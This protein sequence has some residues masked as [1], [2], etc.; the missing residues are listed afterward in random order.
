PSQRRPS[1]VIFVGVLALL[2]L[3]VG[4]WWALWPDNE[5]DTTTI[6]ADG[7]PQSSGDDGTAEPSADT[8]LT[9]LVLDPAPAGYQPLILDESELGMAG[10]ADIWG[11]AG[12]E[13]PFVEGDLTVIRLPS[14][15]GSQALDGFG[16]EPTIEIAGRTVQPLDEEDGIQGVAWLD[17]D[18]ATAVIVVSFHFDRQV[19]IE[20]ASELLTTGRID[21]RGLD[22]LAEDAPWAPGPRLLPGGPGQAIY[23]HDS[24]FNDTPRPEDRTDVY[25]IATFDPSDGS[26]VVA[27]WFELITDEESVLESTT[28]P[29]TIGD[30]TG[31]LVTYTDGYDDSPR[32]ELRFQL[33]DG[34]RARISAERV[35]VEELAALAV[36]ARRA[37]PEEV[38]AMKDE[39]E[40]MV[41]EE[42][43]MS[44]S[45]STMTAPPLVQTT[46][47]SL[48]PGQTTFP[49]TTIT[50]P[51]TTLTTVL[52][53][54][55]ITGPT[56]EPP[57][58]IG[59]PST[60]A[61]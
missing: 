44:T 39:Y 52:P 27:A 3:A 11:R 34:T 46:D 47:L 33:L 55:S 28:E 2:V 30:F 15:G 26:D 40:A 51:T 53:K 17:D 60:T 59:P 50:L 13:N 4:G 6:G 5:T 9:Y 61:G 45:T 16:D 43:Q 19:V 42:A 36:T 12:T 31:E 18:Q 21:A 24:E 58:T 29:V 57:A 37:T 7:E 49:T 38:K 25:V 14:E 32:L 8:E 35:T 22:I 56:T 54:T 23:V 1:P 48:A 20:M 41:A 10:T